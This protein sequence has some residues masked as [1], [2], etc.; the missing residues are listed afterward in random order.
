[1]PVINSLKSSR[2]REKKALLKEETEAEK[3]IQADLSDQ[4]REL[5]QFLLA[6][7]KVLINLETKLARLE[8]VNEKLAEAYEKT[9]DT[10]AIE[11]YQTTLD[12]ETE[13]TES[14]ITKISELKVLKEET[15][16]R[17]K[18]LEVAATP[19]L[20]QRVAQVQEQV[21]NLQAS[22]PTT[23]VARIWSP[24]VQGSIKP[25]QLEIATFSGDVLRWQEFWDTFEAA[26]HNANYS[27]VDKL[28]YLK[29]KLAG[30]ALEAVSGYQLSNSNYDVVIDV[31]K[32]RFGNRQMII[33]A[34]YRNLAHLPAATHHTGRLRQCYDTM[35][36]H[37]RSL[38]ALGENIEHRHFVALITEKL[39]QRVLY[40][41]FML[42]GEGDWTVAKLREL[43]GKHIRA[44][45]MTGGNHSSLPVPPSNRQ[46]QNS[47][48]SHTHN[49]PHSTAGELLAGSGG[50]GPPTR[51]QSTPKCVFC[52]QAHWSDECPKHTTL[53]SRMEKLKGSCFKCLQKGHVM[54]DC[55]KQ[56]ICAHCGKTNHH[57]SLCPKLFTN[58]E[59]RTGT[60][61]VQNISTQS[62]SDTTEGVIVTCGSQVLMQTAI[63]TI[64]N[65]SSNASTSTR[66]ILD[67]G[68]QRTYI[69]ERLA[70]DLQLVLHSPEKL[71][72]ATFGSNKPK[73]IKYRP[74]EL[75]LVLRDGSMTTLKVSVVPHI[76]GKVNRAPLTSEDAAFLKNEGWESKLADS[77]PNEPEST[78]IE[79]LIGNDYYFDLLLPRKMEL[80]GGLSL[81]HSKL[82]WIIGGRNPTDTNAVN[83]PNLLASTIG[84]IPTNIKASTHML[85]NI[86]LALTKPDLDIF[87]NLES[88]GI[89][90]SPVTSDNDKALENF[91]NTVQFADGR[92]SVTWPWRE[93]SPPLPENYQLA[94]GR[95][96]STLQRLKKDPRLLEKYT[97]IIQEQ[98]KRRIIE[99]ISNET[100]KGVL[101]HYI[102]HHAV[103]T[104]T[105]TTTKVRV[106]YD[107][108]AKTKQSNV[109]LNECL[110]RGPV[111]LPD[112]CGLLL[113][114]RCH[115]IAIIADVEKAFLN[116]GLQIQDRDVTRFLWLK[117]PKNPNPDGNLQI[118]RFCRI[119]FGVISSPFLLT[120]TIS[121]HLK[122]ADTHTQLRGF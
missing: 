86:D 53:Q 13:L 35:E 96:K 36:R 12:E 50:T 26:V 6:V 7:G 98:L 99:R 27:P 38:E 101:K 3:L 18:E 60:Q 73:H 82:G 72:V 61:E 39:P 24:A 23:N 9:G 47:R 17:R 119:P 87:W 111:M 48:E 56:R 5:T 79:M 84:F 55:R 70:K 51:Q 121:Y 114:F 41:L 77:L 14:V 95:L 40:Q 63:A 116:I 54:K 122:K 76:T 100:E 118:Y 25:P 107:A 43:L 28:N 16:K 8:S 34:H 10:E 112:L 20:E 83:E 115:P 109:S 93:S 21:D 65:T 75:Q 57:R 29:S 97:A 44:M 59:G 113:R 78:S 49:R 45:E 106:V 42:K 58:T 67:S 52:T 103:I 71:T 105:K 110:Y 19:G 120:A 4:P 102:P 32:T 88:I 108:S 15:E 30:E 80:G 66:L 94:M 91:N 90:D 64:K 22:Q 31:L 11:Q 1:M 85:S 104:P 62:S 92:Y 89:M 2:T 33:D 69:T 37:L 46:A 81:F 68:S 117:D 74:A